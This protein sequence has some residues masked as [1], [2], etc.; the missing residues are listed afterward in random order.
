MI[1]IK[2]GKRKKEK[3]KLFLNRN[4]GLIVDHVPTFDFLVS[5]CRDC[6]FEHY[7]RH[8]P[9][10][11]EQIHTTLRLMYETERMR[12]AAAFLTVLLWIKP[13]F[14]AAYDHTTETTARFMTHWLTLLDQYRLKHPEC[15]DRFP[16]R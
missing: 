13:F 1:T 16:V 9:E 14:P 15:A 6:H 2:K 3:T 11:E 7:G 12:R 5:M 10:N 8:L 4:H